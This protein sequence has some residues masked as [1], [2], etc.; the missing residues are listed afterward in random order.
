MQRRSYL[1]GAA[2]IG[3]AGATAGCLGGVF[4]ETAENV[5]LAEPDDQGAD[6]SALAY[7]AYGESFPAFTLPEAFSAEPFESTEIERPALYTAFYAFCPAECLLL[8]G[9]MANIQATLAERGRQDDVDLV[10]ITFDPTRDTPEKLESNAEQRGIDHTHE[11]WHYLRPEDDAQAEAVVG[12]QLGIAFEAS[13]EGGDA[14]E[15]THITLTFLVN[16]DGVVERAYRGERLDVDRVVS[17][18]ET[19]VDAYA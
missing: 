8:L 16:P 2:A 1:Q 14:Y 18:L 9:S 10:A 13:D 12:E 19:V 5:V 15:F 6:S 17:D 7:P 3:T 4:D 11:Q